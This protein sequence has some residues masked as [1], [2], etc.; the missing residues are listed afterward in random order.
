MSDGVDEAAVEPSTRCAD[1]PGPGL[2]DRDRGGCSR[3][4]R[5]IRFDLEGRKESVE[6]ARIAR[7]LAND[8][9][10]SIL[11]GDLGRQVSCK[12]VEC[13]DIDRI[14]IGR[15]SCRERVCQYV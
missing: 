4:S 8:P 5:G 11:V 9:H 12:V 3:S 14:E 10:R 7:L 6:A 15:A 1:K 2:Q 13:I